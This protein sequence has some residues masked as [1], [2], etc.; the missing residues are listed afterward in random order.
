MLD[1]LVTTIYANI[2]ELGAQQCPN[3]INPPHVSSKDGD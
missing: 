1:M 3:S 2:Q